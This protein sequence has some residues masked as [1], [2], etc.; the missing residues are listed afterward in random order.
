[1][2]PR[3]CF[4]LT[5]HRA[6]KAR[7]LLRRILP[8]FFLLLGSVRGAELP[9]YFSDALARF[10]PEVPPGWAY[11][12]TVVRG[13]ETSVERFDPSQPPGRQW[14]LLQH[15]A[16]PPTTDEVERYQRY[17]ETNNAASA[18]RATF[19][20]GDLDFSS[21]GV[22]HGDSA[23]AT[24]RCR[25]RSDGAEPMLGHLE[26]FLMVA[27]DP[28]VVEKS[29]LRL[30]KPYSPVFGMTMNELEVETTFSRPADGQPGLPLTAVSQFHGRVLWF[31]AIDEDS[32]VSYSDY[33]RVVSSPG[34]APPA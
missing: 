7:V 28:A 11:T 15:D 16:R 22:V 6:R 10:S 31:W 17:R 5:L 33:H 32:R 20:R 2:P 24:I 23:G 25:F 29:V 19:A 30:V 1:M 13:A 26:L 21:A 12:L 9:S 4:R 34:R 18:A 14:T 8:V 27:R 3:P